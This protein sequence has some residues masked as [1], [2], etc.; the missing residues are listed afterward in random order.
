MEYQK[1]IG[2]SIE[3]SIFATLYNPDIGTSTEFIVRY[4]NDFTLMSPNGVISRKSNS[5]VG[6]SL[7]MDNTANS[8]NLYRNNYSIFG[9][10]NDTENRVYLSVS[11]GT[12]FSSIYPDH[13]TTPSVI[14]TSKESVKKNIELYKDKALDILKQ[15]EI[16]QYNFKSEK[17][18]DKKHI[19]FVIGDEGGKYKTPDEVISNGEGIDTYAMTS[20][21]WKAVQE[22]QEIIDELQKQIKELKGGN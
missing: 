2:S 17:D 10:I 12:N 9:Y 18:D 21:L 11:D 22:Q 13:I 19:G 1:V 15:S 7:K 3:E 20:I 4:S 14:Q 5:S 8:L 16:Y 6:N